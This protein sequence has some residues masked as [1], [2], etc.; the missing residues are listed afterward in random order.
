MTAPDEARAAPELAVLSVMAHGQSEAG[1]AVALAFLEADADL[2]EE[3]RSVYTDLAH[4]E[5]LLRRAAV[6][7][8][9]AQLLDPES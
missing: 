4:L 2:D 1:A 6:I 5:R 7:R 9:A 8:D 3:R